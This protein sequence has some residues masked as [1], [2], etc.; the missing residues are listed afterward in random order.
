MHNKLKN[1]GKSVAIIVLIT[2]FLISAGVLIPRLLIDRKIAGS[3]KVSEKVEIEA[4]SPYG[5]KSVEIE[6]R[7]LELLSELEDPFDYSYE[8]LLQYEG[9][10]KSFSNDLRE[11]MQENFGYNL[12]PGIVCRFGDHDDD[13]L[14]VQNSDYSLYVDKASGIP[15]L[16]EFA[17]GADEY[18]LESVWNSV[19][20]LYST[21]LGIEFA[22]IQMDSYGDGINC[23]AQTVDGRLSLNFEVYVNYNTPDYYGDPYE[24]QRAGYYIVTMYFSLYAG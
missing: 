15:L 17:F 4:I 22:E 16:G 24:S 9:S 5:E 7:L 13:I 11:P 6:D 14:L 10:V 3:T 12:L 21:Y 19:R 23:L 18:E 1:L 2:I 8:E 20:G